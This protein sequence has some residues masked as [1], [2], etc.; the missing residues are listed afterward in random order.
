LPKTSIYVKKKKKNIIANREMI[1]KILPIA[2]R[3]RSHERGSDTRL[4]VASEKTRRNPGSNGRNGRKA[5][6]DFAVHSS[7]VL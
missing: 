1:K 2:F 7:P 6:R 4:A 3:R 5:R